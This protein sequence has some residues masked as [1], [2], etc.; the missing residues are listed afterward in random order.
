[1]GARL[2]QSIACLMHTENLPVAAQSAP[3]AEALE[4]LNTGGFGMAALTDTAG[5]LAGVLTDGD[6][7][8]MLC[9]TGF[10]PAQ[11]VSAF[12]TKSP[13]SAPVSASAGQVLDLMETRQI[14]VLPVLGADGTLAGLVHLHDLLGKGRV[15]FAPE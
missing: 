3:L 1:L 10:D 4:A 5:K 6:V 12:M 7:R 2:S 9:R 11:P 8:R 14:T 15:R 13:L